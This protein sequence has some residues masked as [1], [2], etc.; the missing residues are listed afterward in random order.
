[1]RRLTPVLPAEQPSGISPQGSRKTARELLGLYG[2]CHAPWI[3]PTRGPWGKQLGFSLLH[4]VQPRYP[5]NAKGKGL[6]ASG[7][8]PWSVQAAIAT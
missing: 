2:S 7:L 1:M 8:P 4:W 5:G 3:F 6:G